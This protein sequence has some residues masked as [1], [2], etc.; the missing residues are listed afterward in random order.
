MTALVDA[1]AHLDMLD[2]PREAL[3]AA[4]AAGV[5]RLLAVGIDLESS[6]RAA[7]LAATRPEIDAAVG[8]HPHD[9]AGVEDEAIARLARLARREGV[10]AVG[11]T[12]LD[13]YRMKSSRREQERLFRA[14]VSLAREAGLTLVVHARE[15]DR[16]VLEILAEEAAGLTVVLHCFSLVKHVEECAEAGYYVSFAGNVTFPGADDLRGAAAAVPGHLLLSETDS[17]FLSPVPRRGRPNH[18]ANVKYVLETLAAARETGVEALAETVM[19]NYRRAF[20][21]RGGEA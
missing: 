18:P 6:R 20:S 3:A 12:G 13:F 14:Q 4:A 7:E 11:E 8:I 9:A 5:D 19:Q 10:V 17:P 16:Q 1:H 21:P 2:D 15:A